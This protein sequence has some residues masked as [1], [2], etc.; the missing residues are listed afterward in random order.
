MSNM[1]TP[2]APKGKSQDIDKNNQ[3]QVGPSQVNQGRM[4]LRS[5]H[6]SSTDD[7]KDEVDNA[8]IHHEDQQVS[9]LKHRQ[10]VKSSQ[11]KPFQVVQ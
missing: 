3:S 7:M 11:E 4:T 9:P 1:N 6:L 2:N 10:N 8:R 5:V